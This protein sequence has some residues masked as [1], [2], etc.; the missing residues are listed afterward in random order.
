MIMS[1]WQIVLG[2]LGLCL[3]GILLGLVVGYF[4]LRRQGRPW[5]FSWPRLRTAKSAVMNDETMVPQPK[6]LHASSEG[7]RDFSGIT[8][9]ARSEPFP[10]RPAPVV[11]E[12]VRTGKPELVAEVDANLSIATAPWTGKM[13]S[14]QTRVL[15]S[16]RGK[17][18]ILL[19][20]LQE[21]LTEA[22]TDMHLAN[23]LAW[24]S[25]DVGHHSKDMDESYLK[26]CNQIAERL[27]KVKPSLARSGI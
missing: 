26:L 6:V 23:T 18:E 7:K 5:P 14:F 3:V 10:A 1:W 17:V 21:D 24:L 13:E 22:Y 8:P 27:Q 16:N 9:G 11:K 19:P 20:E 15:D 2:I 12:S 4:V 25:T